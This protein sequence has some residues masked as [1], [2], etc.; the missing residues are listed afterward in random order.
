MTE[1]KTFTGGA[2]GGASTGRIVCSFEAIPWNLSEIRI[3]AGITSSRH[4]VFGQVLSD[5]RCAAQ[6]NDSQECRG[7]ERKGAGPGPG[8]CIRH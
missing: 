7:Q 8:R 6:I 1:K 2:T 5:S 3:E 4:W